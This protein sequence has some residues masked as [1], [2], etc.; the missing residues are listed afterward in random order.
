MFATEKKHY[1]ISFSTIDCPFRLTYK[2][3]RHIPRQ[4]CAT[5][6]PITAIEMVDIRPM[7]CITVDAKDGS[8]CVGRRFTLTHNTATGINAIMQAAAARLELVARVFAETGVKDLFMLV[9]KLVRQ[10]YTKPDIVRLRGKWAE[11]DPRQWANRA[12][13]SIA[14]GLGTGNKDA[15][16]MHIQT[17]L[18]AQRILSAE[19]GIFVEPASAIS[20]AG[21]LERAEAGEIPKGATVVLTVTGHGLKDPQWA[22][23]R[24]DG[25]EVTPTS[26]PVDVPTIADV[27]GLVAGGLK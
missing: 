25:S 20:V 1:Q 5:S 19:V 21:L 14:V 4:R 23:R 22:L 15:Q 3:K 11:V 13:M 2:A 10:N 7:R 8:Y 27:L 24:A 9:H 18:A 17:I 26:V 6:Q 16:L 12:D